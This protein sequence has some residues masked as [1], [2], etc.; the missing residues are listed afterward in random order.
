MFPGLTTKLSESV[1]AAAD[2]IYPQSDIVHIS[3]TTA[4]T[5]L[6]TILPTFSGFSGIMILINESGHLIT[7]VTTGNILTAV[8]VT[9]SLATVFVYSSSL[10]KWIPGAIS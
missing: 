2:V 6:T 10:A 8:S 1:I 4:T 7:T 9:T 5:Q 3:D